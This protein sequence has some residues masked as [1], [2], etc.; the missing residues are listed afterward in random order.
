MKKVAV[1]GETLTIQDVAAVARCGVEV[2]IPQ[3]TRKKVTRCR[4]ILE[5]FVEERKVVYGVT[6]GFG[7]LGSVRIP[8]EKIKQLQLNLIRSHASGVGKPL[9]KDA[10]RA[11]MLLRVNTLAKGNSGVRLKTLE[12]L[13]SM[14]N[15]R[16]HPVIPE[17]GSVGASGDLSPLAHMTL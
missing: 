1:D 10:T 13:V 17:K 8:P 16:V 2:V 5:E 7:A 14:I 15:K 3:K 11:L 6:T 4:R 12:T 9:P